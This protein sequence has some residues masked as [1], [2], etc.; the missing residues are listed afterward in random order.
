[1]IYVCVPAYNEATT[2]GLLLWKIREVFTEFPREY[3][4]LLADDASTDD[5]PEVVEPYAKVLPLHVLRHEERRGYAASL[6]E[7]LQLALKRCE[8]PKRDCAITMQADFTHHPATLP[9]LVKSIE[10][11][12]DIVIGEDTGTRRGLGLGER[13]VRSA[14]PRWLRASVGSDEVLDVTSGFG[15]FRLITLKRALADTSLLAAYDPW[16]ANAELLRQA[17]PHA[18]KVVTVSAPARYD[19]RQR[20]TR[21]NV[22]RRLHAVLQA[23]SAATRLTS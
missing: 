12:A 2:V 7:L 8:R 11:G 19:L 20:P 1:M 6:V 21:H 16:C 5:T 18:R 3:Q 9:D 4:I 22:L 17:R 10:S 23:R 13:L 15:A 14:A